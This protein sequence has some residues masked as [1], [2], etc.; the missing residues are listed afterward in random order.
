MDIKGVCKLLI[1]ECIR[2]KIPTIG[3]ID[4][5]INPLGIDY[6][7]PGNDTEFE[8]YTE[9]ILNTMTQ[10]KKKEA[11][12]VTV[13]KKNRK[14]NRLANR[15]KSIL[16][17]VVSKRVLQNILARKKKDRFRKNK[18]SHFNQGQRAT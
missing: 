16:K 17:G 14:I 3:I 11:K 9:L 2:Y 10:E 6:P 7:I 12:R 5:N 1:K 18:K 4:T 8:C 13:H 15:F